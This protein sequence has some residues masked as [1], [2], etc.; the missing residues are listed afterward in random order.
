VI[1]PIIPTK[2]IGMWPVRVVVGFGLGQSMTRRKLIFV[3]AALVVLL[4]TSDL[5]AQ[6]LNPAYLRE[7]PSVERVLSDQQTADTAETAARQI[8][9]R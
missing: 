8:A 4:A 5:A 6:A 2:Q 9:R 3:K 1:G 7:M